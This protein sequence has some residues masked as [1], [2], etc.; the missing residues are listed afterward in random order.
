MYLLYTKKKK[1]PTLSWST[2]FRWQGLL[3]KKSFRKRLCR[4]D[5]TCLSNPFTWKAAFQC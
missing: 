3:H 2:A 1:D 5:R 4:I